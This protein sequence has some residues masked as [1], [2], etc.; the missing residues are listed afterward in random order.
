MRTLFLMRVVALACVTLALGMAVKWLG[1]AIPLK[2][3]FAV[4]A[5]ILAFNAWVWRRATG[6]AVIADADV[7][8]QLLVDIGALSIMLYFSGGATNPFASFYLPVLAAAASML[9]RY[10][11]LILSCCAVAAYSLLTT[12]YVPLQLGD[13]DRAVSYHLAG[14]WV[15]FAVSAGLITWFVAALSNTV[16]QRDV[17]LARAR[18][19]HA[20]N[21]RLLALGIQAANAAHALGTPLSTIAIIV[22]ELRHEI[23]NLQGEAGGTMHPLLDEEL[24]I[25]E[26]QIQL[27]KS[28]LDRMGEEYSGSPSDAGNHTSD[29]AAWFAHFL[30][31]W[32]LRYPATRLDCN[33][34]SSAALGARRDALAQILT[35][36]LDN[37]ARAVAQNGATVS[38]SLFDEPQHAVFRIHDGGD[39]V[40]AA[41]LPRL[42]SEVV[43]GTS[44]GRGI[45]LFLAFASARGIGAEI[46]LASAPGQ[47][48]SVIV[49][50]PL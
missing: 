43:A 25:I 49:R 47:G 28:A 19:Q 37:A 9:P 7:F 26:T 50:V 30:D 31:Q 33:L 45:G 6:N 38:I 20:E 44:N 12:S 34:Q 2:P 24:A 36:V 22:S 21:E 46:H 17:Q 1:I 41:L 23:G 5:A 14:M 13:P 42:G 40:P 32:R 8:L 39:G 29:M 16:R 35:T 18:V 10:Q 27:C 48:T 15:N 4:I 11:A 3:F